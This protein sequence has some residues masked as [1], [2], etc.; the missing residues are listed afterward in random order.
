MKTKAGFAK[1]VITLTLF[2]VLSAALLG[3]TY[4]LTAGPIA[5]RQ[6][7]AAS[8]AI[9]DL[10]PNTADT[11]YEIL[12]IP[13]SSVTRVDRSFDADGLLLGY[14]VTATAQGYAGEITLM[15]AFDPQGYIKGL[16]VLSHTE[17][18]GIGSVIDEPWFG[19]TF[20]GR[21]GMLVGSRRAAQ[22]YEVDITAGATI[23]FNAVLRGINDAS[24][25]LG[26]GAA[27]VPVT[28]VVPPVYPTARDLLYGARFTEYTH[29]NRFSIDWMAA[30]FSETGYPVGYVFFVSPRGYAGDIEMVLAL[31]LEGTITELRIIHQNETWSF[32]GGVLEQPDFGEQFIG[33]S[34]EIEAGDIDM[35]AHATISLNSVIRGINDVMVYFD[36]NHR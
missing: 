15:A 30:G 28:P 7:E 20:V 32:G 8:R 25:H 5:A 36:R 19:D 26:L 33:F 35:V 34:R 3:V 14:A 11:E 29:V 12:D 23:S 4:S 6:A 2:A 24:Q 13:G 18:P 27:T 10:L 17:T 16:Q 21:S 9:I 22:P 1:V 31:D